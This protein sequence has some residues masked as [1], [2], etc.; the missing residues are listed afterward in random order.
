MAAS[1]KCTGRREGE[2]RK[3]E[4]GDRE[5]RGEG[6]MEKERAREEERRER[7]REGEILLPPTFQDDRGT[8]SDLR[9]SKVR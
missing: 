5:R 1:L 3:E 8:L 4:K 6:E 7:K 2:E 9:E